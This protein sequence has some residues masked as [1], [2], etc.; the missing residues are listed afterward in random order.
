MADRFCSNFFGVDEFGQKIQAKS[1]TY[2]TDKKYGTILNGDV[3]DQ[4]W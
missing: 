3:R 2:F 1:R 4:N